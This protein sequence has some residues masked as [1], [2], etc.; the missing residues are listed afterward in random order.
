MYNKIKKMRDERL[1]TQEELAEKSG[2]SRT[3][4]SDLENQKV[5]NITAETMKKIAVDGLDSSIPE[6]FF[7]E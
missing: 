7:N 2:I 5:M 4:I 1:M 6:V 3:T